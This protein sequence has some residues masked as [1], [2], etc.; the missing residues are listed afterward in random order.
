MTVTQAIEYIHA[1]AKSHGKPG[2]DRIR[3]LLAALGNPQ[4]AVRCIHVGGTNGKGSVCAMLDSILR[5]QGLRTGLF[6]SPY[7]RRF[8]E[9]IQV[10]GEQIDDEALAEITARIQPIADAMEEQPN[11]FELITAIG[12]EFFRRQKVDCVVLEVGLGGR[13]D[14]TNII[15]EPLLS[16]I[17]DIDFDHT[18]LLG[19][20]IQ[21]IAT[22]KAGI[23]KPGRP[24][25]FGG[26]DSS[27]CRTVAASAKRLGAPFHTVDRSDCR[28]VSMTLEGTV[29]DFQEDHGL[30]LP[31][32]G[33]YQPFNAAIVLTAVKLLREAGMTISE[34]ALREGLATV[35]WPARFEL[36]QRDPIVICD[37]GHNPQG[38][39]AAVKSMQTY[40]PEQKVLVL[41]GVM[42]DKDY[43]EMIE[44]LKPITK[45][46]FTVTPDN[47]RALTAER[48]AQY[49]VNHKISAAA[50]DSIDNALFAALDAA[51]RDSCPLLCLGSLYLYNSIATI[52][53]RK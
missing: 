48:L 18:A 36:M 29:F 7:I 26:R 39:A 52:L 23:I 38:V 12:F 47:P 31:L 19:N 37:G 8:N 40:F 32:L 27:A 6:T 50:Y 22:E 13:L 2:P 34:D 33:S 25:L 1:H 3:K 20:T 21:A 42:A 35:R 15:E 17:T 46:A 24:C 10:G 11:E 28:V 53:E 16:I 4:H 5:A 49:F 45:H 41:T 43:D 44:N 51:Y 9:R 14:P 30:N